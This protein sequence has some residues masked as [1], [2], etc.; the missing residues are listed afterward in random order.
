MMTK[1]VLIGTFFA[2]GITQNKFLRLD[3]DKYLHIFVIRL[4]IKNIMYEKKI[5]RKLVMQS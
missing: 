2:F 3:L 1:E 5:E 4:C